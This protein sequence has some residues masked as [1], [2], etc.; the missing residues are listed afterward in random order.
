MGRYLL[1]VLAVVALATACA[2][3]EEECPPDAACA[4]TVEVPDVEHQELR[5]A[6]GELV[7]A[8]LDV[9]FS[10]ST[11]NYR[12]YVRNRSIGIMPQPWLR[13]I[14]P[15]PGTSVE[16]GSEIVI[17]TIECPHQAEACY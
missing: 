3:G 11:D 8:D 15:E 4:P 1:V 7:A 17:T 16:I 9:R 10:P 12:A 2:T 13:D 5:S 14:D 6:Y